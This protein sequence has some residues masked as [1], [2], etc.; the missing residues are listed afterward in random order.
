M[1]FNPPVESYLSESGFAGLNDSQD[2]TRPCGG[3][4]IRRRRPKPDEIGFSSPL[5]PRE[6][7]RVRDLFSFHIMQARTRPRYILSTPPC[8]VR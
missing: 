8:R 1:D 7:A 3:L 5:S 6:R 2:T 4:F